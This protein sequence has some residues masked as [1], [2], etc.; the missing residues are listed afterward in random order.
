MLRQRLVITGSVSRGR[1]LHLSYHGNQGC[2]LPEALSSDV[3][4][5][6]CCNYKDAG[7]DR[8]KDHCRRRFK[9]QLL[10]YSSNTSMPNQI[11]TGLLSSH[12]SL[13]SVSS[14]F[15]FVSGQF[16]L[17]QHI[18]STTPVRIRSHVGVPKHQV[19]TPRC[20]LAL[21]PSVYAATY[22]HHP[23]VVISYFIN[24]TTQAVSAGVIHH[25][26]IVPRFPYIRLVCR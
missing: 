8:R 7:Y 13:A 22:S 26:S 24:H 17:E 23:S 11:T 16:S 18:C 20:Y 3:K 21:V 19:T 9:I 15:L 14:S 2:H 5:L 25:L 12:A 6:I 4:L 10:L 1:V